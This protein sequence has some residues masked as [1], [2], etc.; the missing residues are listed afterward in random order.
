M[1]GKIT[2]DNIALLSKTAHELLHLMEC[3]DRKYYEALNMILKYINTSNEPPN[4]I[5]REVIEFII[6]DFISSHY[7][8]I[9]SK[10]KPL[11]K[12]EYIR[13]KQ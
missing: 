4:D 8:D 7:N 11:I 3:K 5:L 13:R 6:N 10:G 2:K 1:K 9:N 12:E